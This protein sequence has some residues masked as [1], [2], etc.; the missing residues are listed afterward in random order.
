[1][2]NGWTP[3][4]KAKQAAAIRRWRPWQSATGPKTRAGKARASQ[5]AKTH[6]IYS[7]TMTD[8]ERALLPSMRTGTLDDELVLA[9]IL[10]RRELAN[11]IDPA[12]QMAL[13]ERKVTRP[14]G[15]TTIYRDPDLLDQII[16][17]LGRIERLE[18]L[19]VR[20]LADQLD[21]RIEQAE[22]GRLDEMAAE[23]IIAKR[24]DEK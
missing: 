24:P 17:L 15:T 13:V 4:R 20:L 10:L 2:A 21:R 23:Y 7:A 18:A 22:A 16:R 3:E 6:G 12:K 9:R 1:M 14:D 19:R 11:E 5:N 8:E